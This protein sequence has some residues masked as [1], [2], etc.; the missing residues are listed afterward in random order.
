MLVKRGEASAFASWPLARVIDALQKLCHDS[1]CVALGATPRYFPAGSITPGATLDAL[2]QWMRELNR[3][4]RH[5]EHPWHAALMLEALIQRGREA[6]TAAPPARGSAARGT[7][8]SV[9][10]RS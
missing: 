6:L 10:S 4:A 9:H 7:H 2:S 3:S 5:A 8:V 1:A